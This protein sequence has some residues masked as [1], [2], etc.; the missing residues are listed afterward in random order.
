MRN[1]LPGVQL[2]TLYAPCVYA[3]YMKRMI[4]TRKRHS[5]FSAVFIMNY[6]RCVVKVPILTTAYSCC[7]AVAVAAATI[8]TDGILV[9]WWRL[10]RRSSSYSFIFF[11]C[12][13]VFPRFFSVRRR[14]I[15]VF[16]S[17]AQINYGQKTRYSHYFRAH[18]N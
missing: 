10:F 12:F 15:N 13:I 18:M 6:N 3:G 8:K 16:S 5:L 17:S 2:Y 7:I 1:Y 9:F 4:Q 11:F 14:I